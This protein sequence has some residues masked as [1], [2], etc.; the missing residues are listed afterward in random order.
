[1]FLCLLRFALF[2]CVFFAD[3]LIWLIFVSDF[4]NLAAFWDAN[5]IG[6]RVSKIRFCVSKERH[7]C[8]SEASLMTPKPK[9]PIFGN[10]RAPAATFLW[11]V[12]FGRQKK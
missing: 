8:L 9:P 4:F 3:L 2:L 11:F 6:R 10:A 7:H 5:G 1:M 12:S